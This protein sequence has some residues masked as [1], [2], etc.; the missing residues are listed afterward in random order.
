MAILTHQHDY[1]DVIVIGEL[2]DRIKEFLDKL[3]GFREPATEERVR[4]DLEESGA[5]VSS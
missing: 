5:G 1:K 4:V 2:V 3:A